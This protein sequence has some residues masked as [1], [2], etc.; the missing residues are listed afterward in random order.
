MMIAIHND[1]ADYD[2][3]DDD[4]NDND[5]YNDD[6]DGD[7][8]DDDDGDDDLQGSVEVGR[9][10]PEASAWPTTSWTYIGGAACDKN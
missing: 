8:S 1:D 9:V 7:D 10:S 3:D 4:D 5:D 6:E 2:D